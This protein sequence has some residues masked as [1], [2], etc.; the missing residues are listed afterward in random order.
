LHHDVALDKLRAL[1]P[2]IQAV[3]Y[4]ALHTFG[5]IAYANA[6]IE[7]GAFS[8]ARA[9]LA[10]LDAAKRSDAATDAVV[11]V[12]LDEAGIHLALGDAAIA[13]QLADAVRR[14]HDAASAPD[15]HVEAQAT[16]LNAYME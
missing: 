8:E 3:D 6:L 7:T 10:R 14:E 5:S 16:L 15:L 1:L 9:E 4:P 2:R 13:V 12:R 11:D